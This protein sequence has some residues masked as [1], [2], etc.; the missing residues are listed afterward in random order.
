MHR[1]Q[2][3]EAFAHCA[4]IIERD[5]TTPF[6]EHAYLE[7]ESGLAFPDGD[8]G[9]TLLVPTQA[10]WD[11]RRELA[12]ILALPRG[13]VRVKQLPIGG[14]F[15]AKGDVHLHRFLALGA[16]HTGRPVKMTLSRQESLFTHAKRHASTIHV[17]LG[18]DVEGK[19]QALQTRVVLDGGAYASTSGGILE[20]GCVINTGPYFVPNLD[21]HGQ[22]WY[23]NNIIGGAMRGFGAPK[24]AFAIESALDELARALKLDPFE[25]RLR[26]ALD[27]ELP[28]MVDHVQDPGV[29][30]IKDTIVAAREALRGL[31]LPQ[32]DGAK[33]IG[34]GVAS[35]VKTV[36]VGRGFSETAGVIIE[37]DAGGDCHV[38]TGYC[39][40]GQG[41]TPFL[42]GLVAE[43][44]GLP[45]ERVHV[46]LPDTAI[47]PE[48]SP[49]TASRQSFMSGNAALMAV[50]ELRAELSHRA[51]D[52][53]D[54]SPESIR[55][56]D[57]MLV[58]AVSGRQM[59]L[60]DLG[61]R[62]VVER[63]YRP[64]E[65]VPLPE[66]RQSTWGT[67]AFH[68]RPTNW[69]YD[70]GTHVAIV[71]VDTTTGA[72]RV[73]KYIAAHD[74]GKALNRIAIEGQIEGGVLMGLGYA[75]SEEFVVKNG[76]NLTDSL[77]KCRIPTAD[78]APEIISVILEIP[79]P[80][81]PLGAKGFAEAPTVPVAPAI[82]NA[83]YD[84]VGVRIRSLPATPEKVLAAM[85]SME[86]DD[87]ITGY[88]PAGH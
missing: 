77:Q 7:P 47:A 36:G 38:G 10:A 74:V 83:I 3:D 9:V 14:A 13:K 69:C 42:L 39:D 46:E 72:V 4:V 88:A 86:S 50:R 56:R 21:L 63:Q 19:L 32:A 31:K 2:M 11:D 49:S 79:H 81:G 73:L 71:E 29:V 61:E 59:P 62:F 76:I 40:M 60:S 75:L 5:Y 65:T 37:L 41:A 68:S 55:I 22:V 1:G 57:N 8:G 34:V 26:N 54:A 28:N 70:Y 20:A 66:D 45:P 18:A 16:L 53:L 33:H 17:K 27:A 30:T 84:A 58:D 35:M 78:Q 82:L 67:T 23:T 51:A 85:R 6:V 15:G 80:L 43:E 64:P 24:I 12:A 44:L 25:V 48:T 87:G 52:I